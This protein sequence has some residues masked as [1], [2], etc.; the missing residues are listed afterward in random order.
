MPHYFSLGKIPHKR[1]LVFR[2]PDGELYAE[3]MVSTEG[4]SETY[5]LALEDRNYDKS[6]IE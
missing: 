1:H 4:F 3:Q 6:W 5:S 2:K